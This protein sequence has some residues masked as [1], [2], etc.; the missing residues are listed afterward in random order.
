M[1][2][3]L[4]ELNSSRKTILKKILFLVLE[5]VPACYILYISK[6]NEMIPNIFIAILFCGIIFGC[7]VFIYYIYNQYKTYREKYKKEVVSQIVYSIDPEWKYSFNESI[8]LSEYIESNIFSFGVEK[9]IGDD[10]IVGQI[11]NTQFKCSEFHTEYMSNAIKQQQYVTIFKGLFFHAN[12]NKQ[13]H[14]ETYI[15]PSFTNKGFAKVGHDIMFRNQGELVKLEN[16]EFE[17]NYVVHSTNQ[18]EARYILTYTIMESMVNLYKMCKRPIYFSFKG[19]KVYCAICF[20]K[21]LFEPTIFRSIVK[22]DEIT[23]IYNLFML[24]AIIIKELNL[25]NQI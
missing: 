12:F 24:N 23:M 14:G 5:F 22:F 16:P 7:L 2:E 9:Q 18:I 13:I 21:D 19:T 1:K 17:K 8:L 15:A 20:K 10:L 3:K 11:E 4:E 6:V 25:N